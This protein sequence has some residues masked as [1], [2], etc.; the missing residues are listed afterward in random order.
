MFIKTTTRLSQLK[1]PNPTAFSVDRRATG[2]G[3]GDIRKGRPAEVP[4]IRRP[5]QSPRYCRGGLSEV[6]DSEQ[7]L[8]HPPARC[9]LIYVAITGKEPEL[10]RR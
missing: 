3:I 7:R 2:P 6:R 1:K 4:V 10:E 9:L 5:P 8:H